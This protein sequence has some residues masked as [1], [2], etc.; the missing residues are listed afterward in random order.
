MQEIGTVLYLATVPGL[1]VRVAFLFGRVVFGLFAIEQTGF[2]A[3]HL[4][5][6]E[7]RGRHLLVVAADHDDLA[8]EQCG[9]GVFD[10]HLRRLVV[11]HGVEHS[12]FRQQ[13]PAGDVRRHEP[14]RTQRHESQI[15]PL[16]DE[17]PK[18]QRPRTAEPRDVVPLPLRSHARRVDAIGE[19]I[20]V[21]DADG[22]VRFSKGVDLLFQ[23]VGIEKNFRGSGFETEFP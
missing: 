7:R 3:L 12:G 4:R 16:V 19:Q 15:D 6:E 17:F 23:C 14:H 18:T 9:Q 20:A 11:D 13:N 8:A 10:G 21:A 2:V 22:R 5:G 1:R